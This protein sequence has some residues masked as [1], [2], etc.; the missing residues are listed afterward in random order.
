MIV[1][2]MSAK[3]LAIFAAFAF[4]SGPVDAFFD[5]P[6]VVPTAPTAGELVSVHI[7]GGECDTIIGADGYPEITRDGSTIRMLFFSVHADQIDW[8][9]YGEGEASFPVAV[10]P[11]GSYTL[12]VDRTY[13][14]I[15]GDVTETIGVV[16]FTVSGNAAA[17]AVPGN[18]TWSTLAL[19]LALA[20]IAT[21]RLQ[22]TIR[23]G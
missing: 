21:Y 19:L 9:I 13:Q 22:S 7:R 2:K 4:A 16:P 1:S 23:F 14:T 12:Q 11:S 20:S 15:F 18:A 3:R 17:I 10:F 6:F 5:P 8:C